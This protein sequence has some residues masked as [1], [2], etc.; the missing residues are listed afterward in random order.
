MLR[1]GGMTEDEL[2]RSLIVP[3]SKLARPYISRYFV[4]CVTAQLCSVSI[5]HDAIRPCRFVC[6]PPA[7]T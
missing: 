6:L 3:A 7:Q 4:G 1:R 2:L 5:G